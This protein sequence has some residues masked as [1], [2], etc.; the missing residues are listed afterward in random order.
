MRFQKGDIVR[1]HKGHELRN[2]DKYDRDGKLSGDL[3]VVRFETYYIRVQPYINGKQE[4]HFD[5]G[6]GFSEE[7]LRLV[8]RPE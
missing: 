6:F 5:V 1:V 4:N 2:K 7:S 8:R 3:I